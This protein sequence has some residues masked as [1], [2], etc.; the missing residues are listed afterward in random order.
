MITI[1]LSKAANITKFQVAKMRIK[2]IIKKWCID[3]RMLVQYFR[4]VIEK[5]IDVLLSVRL[6]V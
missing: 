5:V 2:H 3:M 6:S 4:G 1:I